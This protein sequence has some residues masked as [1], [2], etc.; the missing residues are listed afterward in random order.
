MKKEELKRVKIGEVLYNKTTNA[1]IKVASQL[2]NPNA[3]V[4]DDFYLGYDLVCGNMTT[5][6]NIGSFEQWEYVS[7]DAPLA[8]RY[9]IL[10]E[11]FFEL[12]SFVYSRLH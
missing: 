2:S 11:R 7:N 5:G 4:K 6:F 9:H 3:D 10:Q 8:V 12:E 1:I